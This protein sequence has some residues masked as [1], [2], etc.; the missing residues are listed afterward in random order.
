MHAKYAK[1]G[2]HMLQSQP[3]VPPFVG[4]S[5]QQTVAACGSQELPW[6]KVERFLA[7]D[8]S[9]SIIPEE[10]MGCHG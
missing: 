3:L 9:K 6:L 5:Q 7:S 8:G 4:C 2:V 1:L 10:A